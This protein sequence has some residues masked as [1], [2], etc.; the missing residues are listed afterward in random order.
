[1]GVLQFGLTVV[2]LDWVAARSPR[3]AHLYA[4]IE[5]SASAH[6]VPLKAI[7]C[8]QVLIAAVF[9]GMLIGTLSWLLSKLIGPRKKSK[10]VDPPAG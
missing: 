9:Y 1:M 5:A 4:T 8:F 3:I 2:F 6:D 10:T 7:M